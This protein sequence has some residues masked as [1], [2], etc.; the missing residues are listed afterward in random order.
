[1][2]DR[3]LYI[4]QLCNL[5]PEGRVVKIL[6]SPNLEKNQIVKIVKEKSLIFACP[7]DENIPKIFIKIKKFRRMEFLRKLE[8]DHV[9]KNKYFL[10][11]VVGWALNFKCPKGIIVN[12][13][14][15]SGEIEVETEV[16]LRTYEVDYPA[17]Y[18]NQ[19]Q[20]QIKK[21][22][23]KIITSIFILKIILSNF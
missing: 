9:F 18:P 23:S 7:I 16:L 10:V 20:E 21:F 3:L 13:L 5:R 17:E 11:R 22:E 14:G 8:H 6:R 12:E 1:L 15:N 4:N 2:E 19:I